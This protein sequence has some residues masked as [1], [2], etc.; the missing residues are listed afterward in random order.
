MKR[1]NDRE[2]G[3]RSNLIG[4]VLEVEQQVAFNIFRAENALL[5]QRGLRKSRIGIST[6]LRESEDVPAIEVIEN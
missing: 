4:A 1:E 2:N 5:P 6:C 3:R